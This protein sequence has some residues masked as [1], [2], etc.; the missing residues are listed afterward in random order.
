[1]GAQVLGHILEQL[2]LLGEN[3]VIYVADGV[4]IDECTSAATQPLIS[5]GRSVPPLGMKYLLGV[6]IARDVIKAWVEQRGR[7]PSTREKCHAVVYYAIHDAYLP[8]N[9]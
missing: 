3:L 7:Q 1:M 4:P 9:L 6:A 5:G 8:P 2:E